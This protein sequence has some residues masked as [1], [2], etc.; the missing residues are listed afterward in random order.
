MLLQGRWHF[1]VFLLACAI[2][3]VGLIVAYFFWWS[4]WGLQLTW[5][6]M[7]L[8]I[9]AVAWIAGWEPEYPASNV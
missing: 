9:F 6:A 3:H 1:D 5:L 8:A 4:P 2:I 7:W